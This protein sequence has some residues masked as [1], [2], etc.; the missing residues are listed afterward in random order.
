[1]LSTGILL[2]AMP[3]LPVC[4]EDA[5]AGDAV[6]MTARITLSETSA[7]AEGKN[8]KIDGTKI[9]ISASGSYE[10]SG[11]LNDGQIILLNNSREF[12]DTTSEAIAQ[13]LS[14]KMMLWQ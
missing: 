7:T 9:T 3:L 1:M 12:A 13:P 5:A 6:E 8:V 11:K 2:S 14:V 10:F 4:A